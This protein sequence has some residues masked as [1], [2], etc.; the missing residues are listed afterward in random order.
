MR[1]YID[2]AVLLTHGRF[3]PL[4]RIHSRHDI[5]SGALDEVQYVAARNRIVGPRANGL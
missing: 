1:R 3:L 4:W 2:L 5:G